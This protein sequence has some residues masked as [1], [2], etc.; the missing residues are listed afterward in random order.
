ML[1]SAPPCAVSIVLPNNLPWEPSHRKG[2][3]RVSKH[4]KCIICGVVHTGVKCVCGPLSTKNDGR[5]DMEKLSMDPACEGVKIGLTLS[6]LSCTLD[7]RASDYPSKSLTHPRHNPEVP[8]VPTELAV[9]LSPVEQ[10]RIIALALR[11]ANE[12]TA[13]LGL[14]YKVPIVWE[15]NEARVLRTFEYSRRLKDKSYMKI[16]TDTDSYFNTEFTDYYD[17]RDDLVRDIHYSWGT[18]VHFGDVPDRT[19]R[20]SVCGE[21]K[22][23]LNPSVPAQSAIF[24]AKE[25][26]EQ[27]SYVLVEFACSKD[28]KLS[29]D[30]LST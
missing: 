13:E 27:V 25:P 4:K 20:F 21:F 15:G 8:G 6:C 24:F 30:R 16:E 10:T 19:E 28:S 17:N 2:I 7:A 9:T 3:I 1:T 11:K 23:P 14:D 26:G 22:S 29:C 5:Q 18:Y 12:I